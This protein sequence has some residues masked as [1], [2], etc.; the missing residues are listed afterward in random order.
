MKFH[1]MTDA[2]GIVWAVTPA[3]AQ[4]TGKNAPRGAMMRSS[5]GMRIHE[6]DVPEQFFDVLKTEDRA[7]HKLSLEGGP[8]LIRVSGVRPEQKR[9]G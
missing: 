2:S 9:K 3:G 7:R 1:V 4:P 8:R 5:P 6:V